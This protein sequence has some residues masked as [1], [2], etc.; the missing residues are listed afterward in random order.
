MIRHIVAWNYKDGFGEHENGE[1]A[2]NLKSKLEALKKILD[3]CV[4]LT[5]HINT[6]SSSDKDVVL[7][8]LFENEEAL[9]A[10]QVHP[11]HKKIVA[12][13]ATVMQNRICVDYFE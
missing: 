2:K 6:L 9:L 5:V 12:Y 11:E 10:Y 1:N 13:V 3:G 8:T 7:N 4:E